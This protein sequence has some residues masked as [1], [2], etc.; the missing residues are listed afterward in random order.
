VG[1]GLIR[2]NLGCGDKK[3]ED[4]INVDICPETRGV[5]PDV[6]SDLRKLPFPDEY[7]D[8]IH[9][10]H[11]IEHFYVWEVES[12]LSEWRRVLKTGGK[13]ILELPSMEKII[14]NFID[15]V[16]APGGV[17]NMRIT[18]WG[19]FGDPSYKDPYM[20]HQWCYTKGMIQEAIK[21][22]GFKDVEFFEPRYHKTCRDMRVTAYK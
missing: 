18:W 19:L 16:N 14:G 1:E 22:A 11:V 12:V 3:W 10:I 13:L 4:Y 7:A 20:M 2:L 8:E 17:V 6:V 21:S 9:A 5:K 15:G